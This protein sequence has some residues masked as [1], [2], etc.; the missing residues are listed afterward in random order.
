MHD[1]IRQ[2]DFITKLSKNMQ[3]VDFIMEKFPKQQRCENST[4][5]PEVW[6][7]FA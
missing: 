2:A 5:V 6:E 1:D 3:V 7:N 4:K